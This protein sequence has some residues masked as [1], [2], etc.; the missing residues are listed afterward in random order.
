MDASPTP[1][2]RLFVG[3][4]VPPELHA[5]LLADRQAIPG[6]WRW[7]PPSHW[8]LTLQFLGD[9]RQERIPELVEILQPLAAHAPLP[10]TI[11]GWAGFPKARS[12]HVLVR[13]VLLTPALADLWRDTADRV[14]PWLAK[15]EKKSYRP[16]ITLGRSRRGLPV[17]AAAVQPL[18][19]VASHVHLIESRLSPTGASYEVRATVALGGDP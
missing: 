10:L 3:I 5:S 18:D 14:A 17:P 9:V 4:Y 12:A 1:D 6:D 8:H 19:W 11:S 13:E 15:P 16:H 2:A 7:T